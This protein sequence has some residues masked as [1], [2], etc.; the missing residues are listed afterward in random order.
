MGGGLEGR[1]VGR[2]YG[3]DGAVQ[4]ARHHPH[5]THEPCDGCNLNKWDEAGPYMYKYPVF[6][7]LFCQHR[8]IQIVRH[9]IH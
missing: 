4:V 6:S 5:R 3:A 1:C 7:S 2:V 9:R 8:P